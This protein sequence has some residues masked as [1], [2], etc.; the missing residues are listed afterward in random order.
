MLKAHESPYIKILHYDNANIFIKAISHKGELYEL[1]DDHFIFRGHSTDKYELVPSALRSHL[2]FENEK[3]VEFTSEEERELYVYLATTEYA[4]IT[5]EYK[6]LQEF[7]RICDK[8]GL[9]VPHIENL[10]NSFYPGFDVKMLLLEHPWIPK[11]YWELA[12]L[13][14]HHG[15]KTRL[16]D[17]SYDI[18]VA[19]YFAT[20]GVY[21]DP[22]EKQDL[23]KALKAHMKVK[24]FSP[25]QNMELWALNTDVVMIKPTQVPLHIIQPRYYNNDNLRAQKGVFTFWD[26]I[27]PALFKKNG[28]LDIRAMTD[29]RTLDVQLDSYL[30]KNKVHETPFLYQITIPQDAA[31]GIYSYIEKMGYNASTIFPGYDGVAKYMKEHREIHHKGVKIIKL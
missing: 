25:K 27:Y 30:K 24:D 22:K 9:Y 2:V 29:R 14:Q 31:Y 3:P 10:R 16:L 26:S 11:D 7:F 5:E 17:W 13:A 15:V 21:Y 1:F 20:K 19:L 4:Q 12:A 23:G 8:S 18:F 6:L 28:K